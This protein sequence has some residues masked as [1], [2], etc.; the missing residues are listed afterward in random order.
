MLGKILS[1]DE[2]YI[3]YLPQANLNAECEINKLLQNPMS[4]YGSFSC[5]SNRHNPTFF[6][7]V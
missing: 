6:L 1:N 7:H 4:H 5:I 3:L 2:T